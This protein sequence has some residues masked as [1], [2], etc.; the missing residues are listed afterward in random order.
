M[1]SE[2]RPAPAPESS[3]LVVAREW[4]SET[5]CGE[6]LF[7]LAHQ[8]PSK[9]NR[10]SIIRVRRISSAGIRGQSAIFALQLDYGRRK[11]A[12][13][14]LTDQ[15]YRKNLE[16]STAALSGRKPRAIGPL[17]WARPR[18]SLWPPLQIRAA[19]LVE[20]GRAFDTCGPDPVRNVPQGA[21][22]PLWRP[23]RT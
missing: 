12:L 8:V 19:T 18:F 2:L 15:E 4:E 3:A 6:A 22:C 16:E 5:Q 10:G 7:Q 11:G 21:N 9:S 17:R 20:S 1:R 23:A 14:F 13:P